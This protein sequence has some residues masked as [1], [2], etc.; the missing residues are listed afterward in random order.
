MSSLYCNSASSACCV[1]PSTNTSYELSQYPARHW[2]DH[3]RSDVERRPH[4]DGRKERRDN[5]LYLASLNG[6]ENVVCLLI[7]NV[8]R[9]LFQCTS[10]GVFRRSGGHCR[11][12]A[13]KIDVDLRGGGH[14]SATKGG[15]DY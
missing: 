9:V 3:A 13:R 4:V 12:A 14:D 15:G 6:H 10:N 7:E 8:R 2:I 11:L 5:A 1:N